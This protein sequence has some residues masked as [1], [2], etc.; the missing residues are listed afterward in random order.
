LYGDEV[1]LLASAR[2]RKTTIALRYA[3]YRARA[4]AT[5]TKK[6]WIQLDWSL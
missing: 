3:D 2:L 5:D 1:D 6:F 4:F